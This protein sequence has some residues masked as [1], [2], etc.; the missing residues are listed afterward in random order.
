MYH[1]TCR[2]VGA[3]RAGDRDLF[4]DDADRWR[5][6]DALGTRVESFG[7]RLHQYVLQQNHFHM[8]AET[9]RGNCSA[10]MQSL[11]TAYT[12]YFNLRHQRHGH[13][14]DGRFKAKLV[15]GDA[16][17]LSLS[18]YVHLNPVR[19]AAIEDA[20]EEAL[21]RLHSYYWSSYLQYIGKRKRLDFVTYAPTL[22]LM[23]GA[24]ADRPDRY[25][26]FVECG[27]GEPDEAFVGALSRSR[28]AIGGDEFQERVQGLYAELIDATVRPEDAAMRRAEKVLCVDQVLH[29]LAHRLKCER[30]DFTRRSKGTI[31]RP[32][33]ARYLTRYA[34]LTQRAAADVLGVG[35]GVAVSLQLRR[36]E[37]RVAENPKLNTLARKCDKAFAT[38]MRK[39]AQS[40]NLLL[41]G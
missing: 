18:R 7:V 39:H 41:K 10:F 14:F 38:L 17:R 25:R 23:E 3:W 15:E 34:G 13:L 40:H 8:V 6:L 11:L 16:Y 33:A 2:L 26:Q 5:F 19:I 30:V 22:A 12:V 29:E 20:P 27:V 4:V 35:T 37:Q 1:I 9:P 31:Y 21:R 28:L 36:F 24:A 32:F